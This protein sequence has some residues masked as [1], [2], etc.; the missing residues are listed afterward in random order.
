MVFFFHHWVMLWMWLPFW[1]SCMK[2]EFTFFVS[3]DCFGK[4]SA[5]FFCHKVTLHYIRSQVK[6]NT[7]RKKCLPREKV[8]WCCQTSL[9]HYH[10]DGLFEKLLAA[11]G[12]PSSKQGRAKKLIT[13]QL[14]PQQQTADSWILFN[15]GVMLLG[16]KVRATWQL[17]A[18]TLK[19]HAVI[20]CHSS[21]LV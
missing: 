1:L 11:G 2:G 18:V 20:T 13:P 6:G 15:L 12:W 10:F 5:K 17:R 16:D 19:W 21:K 7:C 8:S 14:C 4:N 9:S 3:P